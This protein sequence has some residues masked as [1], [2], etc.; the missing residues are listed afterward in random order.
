MR[1]FHPGEA[2]VVFEQSIA[3]GLEG[4]DVSPAL[5]SSCYFGIGVLT[6]GKCGR[7]SE[8]FDDVQRGKHLLH[9]DSNFEN[10][11]I[12]FRLDQSWRWCVW[13][14]Q[15]FL[16]RDLSVWWYPRNLGTL[17]EHYLVR[18]REAEWI[19]QLRWWNLPIGPN[20]TTCEKYFNDEDTYRGGACGR[21]SYVSFSRL[22][23]FGCECNEFSYDAC[24]PFDSAVDCLYGC[25]RVRSNSDMGRRNDL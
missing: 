15:L 4:H 25:R 16:L 10:P 11:F 5:E 7:W 12:H 22:L 19:N 17:A 24:K 3:D 6:C 18:R 2:V 20:Y 23:R 14:P 1:A 21:G 9:R 13:Q 8:C